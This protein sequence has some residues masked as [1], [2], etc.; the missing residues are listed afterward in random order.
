MYRK[1][2]GGSSA[3]VHVPICI[4]CLYPPFLLCQAL[5]CFFLH[6]SSLDILLL[7]LVLQSCTFS[8]VRFLS[9][10]IVIPILEDCTED[11]SVSSAARDVL[12]SRVGYTLTLLSCCDMAWLWIE[13]VLLRCSIAFMQVSCPEP[14]MVWVLIQSLV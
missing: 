10:H 1:G 9:A 5:G 4:F 8:R 7:T 6:W 13:L 12:S 11:H 3:W 2:F 14:S